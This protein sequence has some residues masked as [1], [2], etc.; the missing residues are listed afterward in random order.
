[1]AHASGLGAVR[2]FFPWIRFWSQKFV[3]FPFG[4]YFWHTFAVNRQ[5]HIDGHDADAPD[6][7]VISQNKSHVCAAGESTEEFCPFQ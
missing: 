1:M 4:M 7:G 2:E 6:A 5:F 3:P